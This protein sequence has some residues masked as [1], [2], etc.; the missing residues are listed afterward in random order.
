MPYDK[1]CLNIIWMFDAKINI[2]YLG[3]LAYKAAVYE[4]ITSYT[5]YI[6]YSCQGIICIWNNVENM[7]K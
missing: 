3:S 5:S 2:K 7:L 4:A 6:G 1:R